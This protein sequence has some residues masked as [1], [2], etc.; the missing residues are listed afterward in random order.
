MRPLSCLPRACSP[1]RNIDCTTPGPLSENILE[2]RTR[3]RCSS[4][5]EE[6]MLTDTSHTETKTAE[7]DDINDTVFYKNKIDQLGNDNSFLQCNQYYPN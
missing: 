1:A 5:P 3:E 6:N 2:C 7:I 4:K